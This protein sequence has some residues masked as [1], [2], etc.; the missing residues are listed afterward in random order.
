MSGRVSTV[1]D[2]HNDHVNWCEFSPDGT[3]LLSCSNDKTLKVRIPTEIQSVIF[4][5]IASI[6][7]VQFGGEHV[8]VK[9]KAILHGARARVLPHILGLGQFSILDALQC[10]PSFLKAPFAFSVENQGF[11]QV[12]P[13]WSIV[14]IFFISAGN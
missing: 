7:T 12:L 8:S 4:V 10:I 13:R 2:T 1:F 6:P 14:I 9:Y 11:I 3:K 5:I